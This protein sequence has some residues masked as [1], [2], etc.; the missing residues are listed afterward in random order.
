MNQ[1]PDALQLR[2][3][4]TEQVRPELATLDELSIDDLV[5]LMCHDVQ[6]VPEALSAAHDAIASAVEGVV[7]ALERGGRLIYVGAGTAGRLGMLDAAEAGPTF[8]VDEGQVVG[9]LAGGLNAFGVPVENAEDDYE[10][11]ARAMSETHVGALD[12]V[13]GISAS[14]RTPYVLGAVEAARALGAVT[15]GLS[16]NADTPLSAQVDLPI[17]IVVGAELIAG[18]TRMNSGTAQKLVLNIISTASMVRLGKTYGNLMV[19]VRPTNEKLRE[20]AR[21]IVARITGAPD[22][23]VTA[24]LVACDW[25]AKVACAM[26]VGHLDAVAAS[27]LLAHFHGRLRSALVSLDESGHA[28]L[29]AA[30]PTT[31]GHTAPAH[32]SSAHTS[33]AHTTTP[34]TR[35]AHNPTERRLGVG[36]VFLDGTLVPGD[37]AVSDGEIRAIGLAGDGRGIAV[38]GFVD[39]QINGYFGVDLL[40]AEVDEIVAMGEALATDGVMAYQ[41]TLITSDFDQMTRAITRVSEARRRTRRG[42]GARILGVHLEGPFLSPRRAGTHPVHLLRSPELGHLQRLLESGEVAMMTLAPELPGALELVTHCV[43]HD[44]TVSLGHSAASAAEAHRG[45]D[46]GARAVTHLFNAMEPMSARAPGLAGVALTRPDVAVQ[47]IADGVHVA[48]EMLR[49]AF[50]S[51]PQRCILVSDA[52]AAAGVQRDVVQLGDVT[53]LINDGEARRIDGTLAGS[54]GKLRDSVV[55]VRSLGVDTLDALCAVARRPQQLLGVTDL[56]EVRP[57]A[58]AT[59]VVLDDDLSIRARLVNGDVVDEA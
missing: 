22:D 57:G 28:S 32:T 49:L 37:V 18:S 9:I 29:N 4:G 53:V 3:L 5:T 11:G 50:R 38:A 12:C 21:R 52:I 35:T 31:S 59:L 17:E 47:I 19:D 6:R 54:I 7:A 55:R 48:D 36:A 27:E 16:C 1:P 39:T 14:G 45:F 30:A 33:S 43:R 41:P 26:I 46:A 24:A 42:H 13:V 51:A 2:R 34:H 25:R 8:N 23:V 15:V 56:A 20:R 44:V 40:N 10:G 58:A